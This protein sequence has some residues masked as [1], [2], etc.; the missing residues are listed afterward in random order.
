MRKRVL[1]FTLIELMIVIAIIAIIAAIAIPGLLRARIAANEGNASASL[2]SLASAQASFQ[3]G[4]TVD[5]DEDGQGEYG[6][7]N[8]M[9]GTTSR[10]TKGGMA[11]ASA[12]GD[13]S[14]AMAATLKGKDGA[15]GLASKAGYYFHLYIPGNATLGVV[16]DLYGTAISGLDWT[17]DTNND[18]IQQQ[19]NR[20]ICYSWPATF[21]TSG[22]RAFVCDQS[23]DVYASSNTNSADNSGFWDGT[24]AEPAY[25]S[26]MFNDTVNVTPTESDWNN[27]CVRNSSGCVDS[28]HTWV[29]SQ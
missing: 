25:N 8:E 12:L 22:L 19:E 9:T 3:K 16:T 29:P 13:M 27:I 4:G 2:R 5:Q 7:F 20:W 11:L 23:A 26:A 6:V 18:I 17:I 21:K 24:N 14:V 10:R 28:N 15:S 1:G